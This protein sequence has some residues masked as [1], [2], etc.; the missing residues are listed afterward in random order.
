MSERAGSPVQVRVLVLV[1]VLPRST[2]VPLASQVHPGPPGPPV[3]GGYSTEDVAVLVRYCTLACDDAWLLDLR[4]HAMVDG[5]GATVLIDENQPRDDLT[6][7]HARSLEVRDLPER[8]HTY[9]GQLRN[10]H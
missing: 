2:Q 5:R 1:L 6:H 4:L 8:Q 7:P 9:P 10:H 3:P